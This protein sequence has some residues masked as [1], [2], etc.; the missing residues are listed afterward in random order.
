MY[1]MCAVKNEKGIRSCKCVYKLKVSWN[2]QTKLL[3][4]GI[5]GL[6]INHDMSQLH[7]YQE[8]NAL[9]PSNRHYK[10][11]VPFGGANNYQTRQ[12]QLVL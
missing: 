12:S 9:E 8:I 3:F 4:N 7:G 2:K 11:R 6:Y 1:S 5:S 10:N